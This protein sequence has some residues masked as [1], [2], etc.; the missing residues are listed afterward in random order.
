MIRVKDAGF[1]YGD[2]PFIF[3]D[4]SFSLDTGKVLAILGPNGRGKTTLLKTIIGLLPLSQGNI[5]I[6]DQVGY[7]P[8]SASAMF[9][10]SVLDM[11]V[12][13]RGR[14]ISLFTSP[15]KRDFRLAM[16]AIKEL[17]MTAYAGR[18]FLELSGGE[19]QLVLIARALASECRIL[20]LDEPASALDF[21]NQGT[22]LSTLQR[23][24]KKHGLTIVFTTHYPQHAVHI[25]DRV[26]L[27]YT[28]EQYEFGSARLVLSNNNLNRLY[29]MDVRNIAFRH[30]DREV[31]TI[32]P[33]FA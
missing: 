29:G 18:N 25:A 21:K 23:L 9:P 7:V 11:V 24:S 19:K 15:K 12:M 27:M 5:L 28:A 14:H 8:Q 4:F 22:I 10:Y 1:R 26:L 13:G 30:N 20:I 3:R 32:V 31:K 17:G 16:A 33:V 6:Q 2:G